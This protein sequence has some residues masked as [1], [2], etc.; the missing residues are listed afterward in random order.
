MRFHASFQS[1]VSD[2]PLALLNVSSSDFHRQTLWGLVFLAEPYAW[3]LLV[4]FRS[5]TLQGG[6]L[7]LWQSY[8]LWVTKWEVWIL[9]VW[10]LHPSYPLPCGSFCI[11]LAAG[12]FSACLVAFPINSFFVNSCFGVCMEGGDLRLFLLCQV[13]HSSPFN[14]FFFLLFCTACRILVPQPGFEPGPWRWK[15]RVLTAGPPENSLFP[16]FVRQAFVVWNSADP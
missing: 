3:E 2:S 12:L 5:L 11:S 6:F 16:Q 15:H 9:S 4:G 14:F 1:G 8:C 10:H 13:S 7:C